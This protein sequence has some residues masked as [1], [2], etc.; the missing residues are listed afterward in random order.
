LSNFEVL[1]LLKELEAEQLTEARAVIAV[2]KEQLENGYVVP[3]HRPNM[4]PTPEVSENL[5]TVE[6][7]ASTFSPL[8]LSKCNLSCVQA[9]KHLSESFQPMVSQTPQGIRKLTKGLAPYGLTKGEKLQIVNLAPT[10]PVELYVV[11]WLFPMQIDTGFNP[12]F[13]S[14]RRRIGRSVKRKNG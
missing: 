8:G 7:E 5:R 9:I 3:K 6:F 10:Q 14:D 12:Q 11:C 4:P 2:K 1:T 13:L